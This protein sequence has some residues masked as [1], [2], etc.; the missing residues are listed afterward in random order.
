MNS[1][2]LNKRLKENLIDNIYLFVGEEDYIKDV[3]IKKIKDIVLKNDIS[4]LNF[5]QYDELP[6]IN[7]LTDTIESVPMMSDM[8]IVLLNSLNLLS[9]NIKK[10]AKDSITKILEDIPT[11]TVIIIRE[12]CHASKSKTSPIYKIAEKKG[13]VIECELLETSE[14]ML[15]IN[16][17]FIKRNKKISRQDLTYP[18]SLCDGNIN[19]LLSEVEKISSYLGNEEVVRRHDIDLLVKKSI[20]DRI[21]DLFDLIIQRNKS[22]AFKVLNDLKLLKNQ[23]A[24]GQIFSIICDNFLNMYIS[25]NNYKEDIPQSTTISLLEL[26]P[27]RAFLVKKL[28]RQCNGN[29]E[30]SRLERIIKRLS[31]MDAQ[32]KLGYIDPYYAIEEII[33]VF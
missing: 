22:G 30:I 24:P 32:I 2:E 29:I 16:K 31:E 14:M 11:Y 23:H 1:K 27:N 18:V 8:K 7:E 28:L 17:E 13:C 33:S 19:A 9:K 20:E 6:E 15:F 5:I 10:N 4:G 12:A 21:F 26:P 25:F 3:Y